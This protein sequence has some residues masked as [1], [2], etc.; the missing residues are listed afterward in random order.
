MEILKEERTGNGYRRCLLKAMDRT[1]QL[2]R[3]DDVASD[4]GRIH[5]VKSILYAAIEQAGM[6]TDRLISAQELLRELL[7]LVALQADPVRRER[8]EALNILDELKACHRL[9]G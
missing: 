5:S 4:Y 9:G 1:H 8:Q 6:E 3:R 7:K 2:L